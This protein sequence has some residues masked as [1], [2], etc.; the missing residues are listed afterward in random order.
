VL[1]HNTR[2]LVTTLRRELEAARRKHLEQV[3]D[4]TLVQIFV[5]NRIYKQIEECQT[6]PQVQQAVLDGVNRFRDRL[7]RDVTHR[8]VEML[9]GIKIKRIS[10]YDMSRNRKEIE[11]LLGGVERVDS[12]LNDI[13]GHTVQYLRSIR[14]KYARDYPRRTKIVEG[15]DSIAVR[16]LTA[17]ELTLRYDRQKGYLGHEV[18]GDE[19]FCCSS[20]DKLMVVRA[21]GRYRVINPPDKLFVDREMPWCAPAERDRIFLMVYREEDGLAYVKRFAFGGT[22]LNREYASIPPRSRIGL[23]SADDP[24]RLYV[25]YPDGGGQVFN[26]KNVKVRGVKTQGCLLTGKPVKSFHAEKPGDWNDRRFGRARQP[27]GLQ[28]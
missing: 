20:L 27:L 23:F 11:D 9:L 10:R 21:D 18:A 16:E 19:L 6:L 1:R 14:R 7:H 15:F 24:Q 8:D 22:I 17:D 5:E 4:K 3:H 12:S 25:R 2:Q 26:L 13:V 28:K